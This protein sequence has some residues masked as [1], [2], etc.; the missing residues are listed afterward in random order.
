ML[1]IF[2]PKP[3]GY[4]EFME[5]SEELIKVE[6]TETNTIIKVMAMF[7]PNDKR[8]IDIC[9]NEFNERLHG[10][11]HNWNKLNLDFENLPAEYFIKADFLCMDKNLVELY[12]HLTGNKAK[13]IP[14]QLAVSVKDKFL[15]SVE[16]FKDKYPWI[17]NPPS[18]GKQGTSTIGSE[19][20]SEFQ[21]HY[22]AY[23]EIGYLLCCGDLLKMEEVNKM[24][25]ENFLSL[26]EYA[27]RKR[28]IESVT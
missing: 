9:M 21:T 1:N 2:K 6:P 8:S 15:K 22:G 3:I 14:Y 5:F 26:G 17:Y 10:K 11:V 12:N 28:A 16:H 20:R 13:E 24:R 18:L 19:L 25:L 4:N 23:T 7:Y 27:L